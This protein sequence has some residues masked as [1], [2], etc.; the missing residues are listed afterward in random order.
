MASIF[1]VRRVNK[2]DEREQD[3]RRRGGI[4]WRIFF[5]KF[6]VNKRAFIR[7]DPVTPSGDLRPGIIACSDTYSIK[8]ISQ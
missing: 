3:G 6:S 1:L 8:D 7:S 2:R 5:S 4:G